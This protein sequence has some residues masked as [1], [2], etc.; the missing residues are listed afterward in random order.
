MGISFG[1]NVYVE[2]NKF[3]N[4]GWLFVLR[5]QSENMIH[6]ILKAQVLSL[7]TN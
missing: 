4:S 6:H 1:I 7:T 3:E 2:Y 5:E